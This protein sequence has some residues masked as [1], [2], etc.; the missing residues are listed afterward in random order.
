M[1]NKSEEYAI[2]LRKISCLFRSTGSFMK[3]E[4]ESYNI[5][6]GQFHFFMY[7]LKNGDGISQEKLS[8]ELNID[9]GTTARALNIL[10]NNNYVIK[11]VDKK[12]HRINRIYL[13]DKARKIEKEI[14]KLNIKWEEIITYGISEEELKVF[15][16][17]LDKMLDNLHNAK[18]RKEVK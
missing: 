17:V 3:K 6:K 2:I 10:I 11:K 9:K 12:D 13:T 8:E 7:L 5:G 14:E 18:L 15:E 4:L 1:V 16:N